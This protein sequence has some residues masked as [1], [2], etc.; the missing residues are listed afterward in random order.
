VTTHEHYITSLQQQQQEQQQI[1]SLLDPRDT[2]RP[3]SS[4]GSSQSST[5]SPDF[6]QQIDPLPLPVPLES[7]ER[8]PNPQPAS[9]RPTSKKAVQHTV[10]FAEPLA[11][12]RSY[13]SQS[14]SGSAIPTDFT[15]VLKHPAL[16]ISRRT[17]SAI[18]S[19]LESLRSPFPFSPDLVEENG[20]MSDLAGGPAGSR[21]SNGGA[22]AG[23]VP[24]SQVQQQA[25]SSQ[26]S[27]TR[28]T[29]IMRRRREK[30]EAALA[31]QQEAA[32]L[33]ARQQTDSAAAATSALAQTRPGQGSSSIPATARP[34]SGPAGPSSSQ[35]GHRRTTTEPQ[36]QTRTSA[37]SSQYPSIQH[38][39]TIP[40]AAGVTPSPSG[41]LPAVPNDPS[42]IPRPRPNS[43][44][45]EQPRPVLPTVQPGAVPRYPPRQPAQPQA[46]PSQPRPTAATAS[47]SSSQAA[48]PNF[49]HA[50]ERWETLSSHWEGLTSY[51]IRRLEQNTEELQREPLLQQLSRQVTDLSAAGANLF[52]AV[53]E[54][55]RLR[56]SSERK[57]QRWFHETRKESEKQQEIAADF[58]RLLSNERNARGSDRNI[59]QAELDAS[60][61]TTAILEK[62]NM[63]MQREQQIS[64]E[65]ARRA[66]EELGRREQEAR[67]QVSALRD[68]QPILIGGIQVFPMAHG[69]TTSRAPQAAPN[70]ETF[71][72]DQSMYTNLP[73]QASPTNTDPFT[74]RPRASAAP[75]STTNGAVVDPAGNAYTSPSMATGFY[76]H[77]T[78]YLHT[79][80]ESSTALHATAGAHEPFA[81]DH[82]DDEYER[83]EHGHVRVDSQGRPILHRPGLHLTSEQE[84][85]NSADEEEHARAMRARYGAPSSTAV[86]YP[87]IPAPTSGHIEPI[88]APMPPPA[89]YGGPVGSHPITSHGRYETLE[90][91]DYE[92]AGYDQY[93]DVNQIHSRLSVVEEE[94]NE[95]RASEISGQHSRA[96][97]PF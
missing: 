1:G 72:E 19:A 6:D 93:E 73:D 46:G 87:A 14:S 8:R 45:Q 83:D 36:P 90:P 30:E 66:W 3:S 54:L 42:T 27:L 57:F 37:S 11:K 71:T 12:H 60:Q 43:Q 58:E 50:F 4:S 85:D 75:P 86:S 76:K 96:P 74:E 67:D 23:P 94:E 95:S 78:S 48:V 24:V 49:P 22:R 51:W 61:R 7:P 15:T 28:P 70:R 17:A 35:P 88:G 5:R 32:R 34:V 68:G 16:R 10:R 40:G 79:S 47:A 25:T 44:S 13:H 26:T 62:R 84:E 33:A 29:D 82:E 55:Q 77:P 97:P 69:T 2:S 20:E 31:A 59:L 64:K 91:A 65:E 52:H 92:G 9:R 80:G 89:T 18:L 53:V 81:S 63:E 38:A 21:A 39:S 41:R 56:A